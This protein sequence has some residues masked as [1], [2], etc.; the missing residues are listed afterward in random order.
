MDSYVQDMASLASP[1]TVSDL[2]LNLFPISIASKEEL[3]NAFPIQLEKPNLIFLE[4][5]PTHLGVE[6]VLDFSSYREYINIIRVYDR[7]GGLADQL[8]PHSLRLPALIQM[9][10]NQSFELIASAH[11]DN[12]QLLRQAFGDKI[13]SNLNIDTNDNIIITD[14]VK[15]VNK[16]VTPRTPLPLSLADL[17]NT[18]R[19]S[20]HKEVTRFQTL[21]STQVSVLKKYFSV[22]YKYFP[23]DNENVRRFFKRMKHW[24]ANKTKEIKIDNFKAA[25]KISDGYLPPIVQWRH[26]SASKSHFRGYP[27]GLWSM[28]HVMT[29]KEYSMNSTHNSHEVLDLMRDFVI[30]FFSCEHC[31]K[32]FEKTSRRLSS[33]LTTAES[34]VLWL[35]RVHNQVN[36]RTKGSE[37]EDPFF[38]KIQYPSH[39]MCSQCYQQN[40]EFNETNFLVLSKFSKTLRY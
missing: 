13:K 26:C 20:L 21:N 29:V 30:H 10:R 4:K 28:F 5:Y 31:A 15:M 1:A 34:S 16:S 7:S 11:S 39:Q 8:F 12:E 40:N 23:F 19:Y 9:H 36:H 38:P 35:W 2:N 32:H 27:C 33:V 24:F 3:F 22:V 25:M 6:I 37:S 14:D 18:L 17:Y